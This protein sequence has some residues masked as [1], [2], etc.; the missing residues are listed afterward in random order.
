MKTMIRKLFAVSALGTAALLAFGAP[1]QAASAT[2]E[3]SLPSFADCNY[4]KQSV[5]YL[6]YATPGQIYAHTEK[7]T[8]KWDGNCGDVTITQNLFVVSASG[9]QYQ[10]SNSSKDGTVTQQITWTLQPGQSAHIHTKFSRSGK[11]S[12]TYI[13]AV[14]SQGNVSYAQA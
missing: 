10:T 8:S 7:S 3:R 1:A 9:V 13:A 14:D 11:S 2:A 12:P 5:S 4:N 6:D